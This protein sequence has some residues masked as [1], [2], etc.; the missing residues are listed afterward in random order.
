MSRFLVSVVLGILV[1]TTTARAT[2]ES[3][4]V[5][6]GGVKRGGE[7]LTYRVV[8]DPQNKSVV[9]VLGPALAVLSAVSPSGFSF[10][11]GG[12]SLPNFI[13]EVTDS[14]TM[15]TDIETHRAQGAI[16][17][18][19]ADAYTLVL[20][21]HPRGPFIVRLLW[22][23]LTTE[24][25]EGRVV[26]RSDAFIR[27]VAA[28]G[29]EIFGNVR[30]FYGRSHVLV[31]PS[32]RYSNKFVLLDQAAFEVAA[33]KAG[34]ETLHRVLELGQQ[35]GFAEK[36]LSDIRVAIIRETNALTDWLKVDSRLRAERAEAAKIENASNIFSAVGS[37]IADFSARRCSLLF[38]PVQ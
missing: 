27:V 16:L 32:H 37:Q 10:A 38:R 2:D 18:S 1:A 3:N 4:V 11:V 29:H 8:Y 35:K 14:K 9:E 13:I 31:D 25:R 24:T 22:D 26:E 15:K 7:D 28:L 6:L 20:A 17:S 12:G 36:L 23:R 30:T 5:A 21:E 34:L 19:T 33:F